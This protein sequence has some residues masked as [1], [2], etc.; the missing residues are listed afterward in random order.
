[1]FDIEQDIEGDEMWIIPPS[2]GNDGDQQ[3]EEYVLCDE[4]FRNL[5][6]LRKD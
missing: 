1:M 4:C 6:P 2:A 5:H 3:K